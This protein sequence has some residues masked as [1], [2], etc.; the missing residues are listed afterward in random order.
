MPSPP[1]ILVVEDEQIVALDLQ[2]TLREFGYDA[3]AIASSSEAA[4]ARAAERCP[5]LVLM[6]IR[7][8]GA[9]DGV[10]TAA[11]LQERYG[12]P[13]VFLTAHADE[14]TIDRA[15]RVEPLGYLVK[16]VKASE[17]RSVVEVAL[18]KHGMERRLRERERWFSTTLQ[19][20]AD[21]VIAVDLAGRVTF[22]NA[23]AESLTGVGADAAVGRA[24]GEVLQI[25]EHGRGV[26]SPVLAALR[27]GRAVSLQE[28]TLRNRSSGDHRV[29]S[30]SAAPVLAD[31][32]TLG[33]VMVFRDVTEQKRLQKQ[34]E[35]A[36]RLASLG[37]MAAGVAH[38]VNNPLAAVVANAGFLAEE[39]SAAAGDGFDVARMGAMR[40]ALQDIQSGA[41]RIGRIVSDLCAFSRPPSGAVGD[42]DLGRCVEWALRTTAHEFRNRARVRRE[43]Q[44]APRVRADETRL[45][46]V[47][48]NLLVNAAHAIPPGDADRNE[49][50][51]ATRTD[52]DG[53]AV[54]E[55]R[56]TGAGIPPDAI[57]RIFD[58]FFTTKPV[59]E[60]TGL[61]LSICHGIVASL[62]GEIRVESEVG[63]GTAVYVTL[64][65]AGAAH[66]PAGAVVEPE[67]A[68]AG[69]ILVVDDE[70]MVL[71][72][73]RRILAAHD[74]ECATSAK[75]ALARIDAGPPFDLILTDLMMP[76][77]TGIEFYESLLSRSP[78]LARRTVFMTGG[79]VTAR[80]EAFFQSVP[81]VCIEKPFEVSALLRLVHELLPGRAVE[82][83]EAGARG[84]R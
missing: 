72:A 22:M 45:G 26:E 28:G 75:D 48:I 74:V 9:G 4:V 71:R 52:A 21:A 17:L 30:D 51:V 8:K 60:G 56:D 32:Q 11:I 40:E 2:Q 25:V 63:R 84:G 57:A 61:G 39:L 41:R 38:E 27:E 16:P 3:F 20:I 73:L 49:V 62:G 78:D 44:D 35:L 47:L 50:V 7:I 13:V 31:G 82:G 58:P 33:A 83:A 24:I 70:E 55:V 14:G 65:P 66:A 18:Y 5:D 19:S 12:V 10:D 69:R 42:V 1:S 77:M 64:C 67:R 6:D 76:T 80:I 59:G 79:T 36:D 68:R 53:R 54:L 29:I 43:A 23:V 34:L 15:K 46:Q 81:N 37:T